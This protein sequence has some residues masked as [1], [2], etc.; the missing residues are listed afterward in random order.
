MPTSAQGTTS[1]SYVPCYPLLSEPHVPQSVRTKVKFHL[2][3]VG[4]TRGFQISAVV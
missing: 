3:V 4:L 1:T 2:Y